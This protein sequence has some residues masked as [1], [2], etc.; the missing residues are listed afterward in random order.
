LED[1]YESE[2]VRDAE[3]GTA[4]LS[5]SD[6]T[7]HVPYSADFELRTA[8]VAAVES[9]LNLGGGSLFNL[10][11]PQESLTDRERL[12]SGGAIRYFAALFYQALGQLDPTI[13]PYG[14]TLWTNWL[15]FPI[16]KK[17]GEL[18]EIT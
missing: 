11:K 13:P 16:V 10:V 6:Q 18:N 9:S 4:E 15:I 12:I 3:I 2:E 17:A 1:T 7:K 14:S 5:T 8:F